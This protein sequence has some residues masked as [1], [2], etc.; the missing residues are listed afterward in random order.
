[1]GAQFS[2]ADYTKQIKTFSSTVELTRANDEELKAFLGMSSNF[3]D[4]FTAS[5]LDDFRQIKKTNPANLI[6]MISYAV[7]VMFDAASQPSALTNADPTYKTTRGAIHLLNRCI[8]LIFEDK[9]FFMRAMW[10]E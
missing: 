2:C 4:V 7:K 1:M 10:H 9:E 6:S 5:T 3:V 8:P